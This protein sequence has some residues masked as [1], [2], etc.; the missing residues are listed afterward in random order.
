MR[1]LIFLTLFTSTP[2]WAGDA[3]LDLTGTVDLGR[4]WGQD[5]GTLFEVRDEAGRLRGGAGFV[6]VYNTRYRGDR[7]QLQ[8]FARPAS[9]E[10][11]QPVKRTVL[12]RSTNDSGAY[13]YGLNNQ[14]FAEGHGRDGVTRQW[15]PAHKVWNE[16]PAD[17]RTDFGAT[18]VR[19]KQ[20]ALRNGRLI[21]D[22][23]I[24]LEKPEKGHY[25][26]PYYAKG[27][28][29][30]YHQYQGENDSSFNRILA[31]PW[32]AYSKELSVDLL[33]AKIF[34]AKYP[35]EFPY[36]F[37][38]LA[39]K[40]ITCSNYGGVYAFDGNDWNVLVEADDK[41]S[42]Q[43][44]SII[45][46]GERL[47]MAQYPTGELFEYNGKAV[48]RLKG[49]PPRLQGVSPSAR[50]AQTTMIYRGELFVGVWPWAELWRLNPDDQQWVSMGR[51]FTQ[52]ELSDKMVHPFENLTRELKTVGNGL[53]QRLTS[54]VPQ[55]D[56]MYIGTS[57]KRGET[58]SKEAE[59]LLPKDLRD[60][61]GAIYRIQMP[62]NLATTIKWKEQPTKLRFLIQ[63]G[64]MSIYQDGKLLSKCPVSQSNQDQ[65]D[66]VQVTSGSGIF[67]RFTGQSITVE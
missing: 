53:G 3:K 36:A 52:P 28:L 16:V 15:D 20:L 37:G 55:E 18:M 13:L 48:T 8:F 57:S 63:D 33:K 44:Y 2:I 17:S 26:R 32:D 5:F 6:G 38:Q 31:I 41:V 34:E 61:Y 56:A 45:N 24:I 49:W 42:Y 60:Q 58:W 47:L 4:D 64:F 7:Y 67:G 66:R 62:G 25:L 10:A 51:M 1:N 21:Y 50:E 43:I 9:A 29:T 54:L 23:K 22:G 19:G 27:M 39:G 12:S 59:T 30:F 11:T 46:H 14:L 40:I 65:L 35:R